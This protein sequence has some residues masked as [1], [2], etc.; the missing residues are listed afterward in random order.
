MFYRSNSKSCWNCSWNSW[1]YHRLM[2][3][4]SQI[5]TRDPHDP[6]RFVDLFDPRPPDLLTHCQL[7]DMALYH[8]NQCPFYSP[9]LLGYSKEWRWIWG[10]V[11]KRAS[12]PHSTTGLGKRRSGAMFQLKTDLESSD[13]EILPQVLITIGC[14]LEKW[15]HSYNYHIVMQTLTTTALVFSH[16]C[17]LLHSPIFWEGS[18]FSGGKIPP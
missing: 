7:C 17:N 9:W 6:S 5:L 11:M 10:R 15:K 14:S 1:L 8:L 13:L 18:I 4:G 3:R 16:A 2:C 12:P